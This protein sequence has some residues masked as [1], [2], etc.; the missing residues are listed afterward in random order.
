MSARAARPSGW[1]GRSRE[2]GRDDWDLRENLETLALGGLAEARVEADELVTRSTAI[3]RHAGRA[4]LQSVRRAERRQQK[5][6]AGRLAN[7]MARLHLGPLS[8]Q[9][10]HGLSGLVLLGARED[11]V[12]SSPREGRKAFDRCRP[13]DNDGYVLLNHLPH[14]G[15]RRLSHAQRDHRRGVPELHRPLSRSSSRAFST[16][17]VGSAGRG[18]FQK[19]FGSFPEPSR[20]SPARASSRTWGG[21]RAS[22]RPKGTSFAIGFPRSVTMTSSP[23]LTRARYS[24]RLAFRFATAALVMTGPLSS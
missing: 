12:A 10:H 16:A 2:S 15:T 22:S 18:I 8:R 24:L 23:A 9:A 4:A 5:H 11:V 14:E 7:L 17:P 3:G 19:P 20:M 6:A 13:P 21:N 1:R